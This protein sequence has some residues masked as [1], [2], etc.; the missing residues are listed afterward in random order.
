MN[1]IR[2]ILTEKTLSLAAR[3]WYTF[4]VSLSSRKEAIAHTVA[5]Q[6]K[7]DV[8]GVRT[9]RMPGKTRRVGKMAKPILVP[10][11]KKAL[12]RLKAGQKIDAFEAANAP[13]EAKA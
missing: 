12:I 13:S 11:W 3:G 9:I 1:I 6:Y 7:V 10:S 8:L 2:P 4:A 5:H